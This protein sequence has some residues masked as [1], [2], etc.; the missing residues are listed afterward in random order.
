MVGNEDAHA[1]VLEPRNDGL[2]VG[3]GDGVNTRERFVQQ[4]ERGVARE[5]ARNLEAAA[6]ATRAAHRLRLADMRNLEFLEQFLQ[7]ALAFAALHVL[8]LEDGHDVVLDGE[9]AEDG[10]F[11]RQ[12][13]EP[14]AGALVH[15]LVRHLHVVQEDVPRVGTDHA[16][17]HVERGRL[18]GTVGPEQADNLALRHADGHVAHHLASAVDLAQLVGANGTD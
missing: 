1:L 4:E 7:A 12:V 16:H 18:P 3:H 10:G 11:L 5:G 17:D 6:F 15:G 9:L 13:A 14:Q 8:R 2:D